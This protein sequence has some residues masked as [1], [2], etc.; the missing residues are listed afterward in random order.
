M[1]QTYE[2]C[3]CGGTIIVTPTRPGAEPQR[4]HRNADHQPAPCPLD[5]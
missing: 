3:P 1:S 5:R 4:E 2:A